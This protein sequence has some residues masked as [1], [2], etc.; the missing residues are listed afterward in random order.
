MHANFILSAVW[1]EAVWGACEPDAFCQSRLGPASYC[2]TWQSP[3][4][5]QGAPTILNCESCGVSA[6]TTY[7]TT[8]PILLSTVTSTKAVT[9][10]SKPTTLATTT[11]STECEFRS[12][13]TVPLFLWVEG[14]QMYT[15][16]EFGGFYKKLRQ[17]LEFNCANTK[18]VK[19]VVR[20]A[21]PYYVPNS[22]SVYWPPESSPLFTELIAKLSVSY[23]VTLIL[24]PYVLDSFARTKW[25][26]FAKEVARIANPSVY[27]GLFEFTNRWRIFVEAASLGGGVSIDGFVIDYEEVTANSEPQ[28]VIQLSQAEL[29][30]FR[31]KY[32]KVKT[33]VTV[34]YDDKKKINAFEP[35]MDYL[36]LQV[37]DLYYPYVGSDATSDSLF[38]KYKHDP[39][40]LASV[41]FKNVL[42][43]A[44]TDVY[45]GKESKVH[46]M[47]ST[48]T[49]QDRACLYPTNRGD[50]GV[51]NEFNWDPFY[52][53]QFIQKMQIANSTASLTH[54]IYTYN[55]LHSNW[56]PAS[57]RAR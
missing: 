8:R 15:K 40:T 11:A 19:L 32:P 31:V 54:G 30:P 22:D 33:G 18:I 34:G 16:S 7:T 56:L 6:T 45:K 17:F 29:S 2:R 42:Y 51:N 49:L 55:F 35:Y 3:A 37:Y 24:Y 46:L 26:Q 53:N 43:P 41:L 10:T 44:I 1:V 21:H 12:G 14:P 23:K 36:F 47:W 48:Q 20:T 5:C 9:T 28:F 50:C 13:V 52:F 25:V 39:A 27:D 38:V 4:V 57:L